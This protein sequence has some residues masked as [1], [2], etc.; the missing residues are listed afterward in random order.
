[1]EKKVRVALDWTVDLFF[2]RD[3]VLTSTSAGWAR[4]HGIRARPQYADNL[5]QAQVKY[6]E[7]E[8][9]VVKEGVE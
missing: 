6:L 8:P 2:P 4:P 9:D 7:P 3:I 1:M 5:E